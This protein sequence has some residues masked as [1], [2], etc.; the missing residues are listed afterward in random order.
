MNAAGKRCEKNQ[1]PYLKNIIVRFLPSKI[2]LMYKADPTNKK[3]NLFSDLRIFLQHPGYYR[4]SITDSH[5]CK[6]AVFVTLTLIK[7]AK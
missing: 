1:Q 5:N 7:D 6:A 2:I 3:I 4:K